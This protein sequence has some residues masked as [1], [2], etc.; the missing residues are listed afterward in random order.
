MHNLL[1]KIGGDA[2]TYSITFSDQ[3]SF[4]SLHAQNSG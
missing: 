2:L 1:N 3:G 4:L